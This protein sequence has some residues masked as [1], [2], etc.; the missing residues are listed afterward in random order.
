MKRLTVATLGIMVALGCYAGDSGSAGVYRQTFSAVPAAELPASAA[1]VVK[2]AKARDWGTTTE[3]SVKDALSVNP[4]A[5]A[6]VVAAISKAVPEMASIAASTAATQQPKLAA[7]IAKAAAAAAPSKVGKI[8]AAVCRAV[9]NDYVL[10]SIAASQAVPGSS[11][12]VLNAVADAIPSLKPSIEA[13]LA[14]NSGSLPSVGAVM[15]S[16]EPLFVAGAGLST[17][18][19]HGRSVIA[20]PSAIGMSSVPLFSPL[21]APPSAGP[22]VNP[23][24]HNP[25]TPPQNITT[26]TSGQEQGTRPPP[27]YSSP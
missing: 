3:N 27:V 5:A 2:Q 21:V 24:A 7:V 22:T 9:P 13:A 17:A 18:S 23:P 10:I 26:T 15:T 20:P 4:S 11:L 14:K 25:V 6:A 16:A 19:V 1:A 8:V 12:E